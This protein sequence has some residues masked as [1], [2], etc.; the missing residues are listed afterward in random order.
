M[1]KIFLSLICL[2]SISATGFSQQKGNKPAANQSKPVFR[3]ELSVNVE[4]DY[5]LETDWFF[6]QEPVG[7]LFKSV[8]A[9]TVADFNLLCIP[10]QLF[11]DKNSN[12]IF[13]NQY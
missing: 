13:I 12:K 9:A 5:G 3:D 11:I 2:L 8:H 10:K 4:Q 7:T 1:K 6:H